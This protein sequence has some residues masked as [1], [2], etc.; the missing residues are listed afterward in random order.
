M[1]ID[2]NEE[3]VL[4]SLVGD[5]FGGTPVFVHVKDNRII[6]VRAMIF[7]ED[8]AKPWSI[9]VGNRVFSPPKRSF[10]APYDLTVR[11]RTYNPQRA[12]YPLKRADFKPG[13]KS[14]TAN[15]GKSEYVRISWDEAL[16][17]IASEL[18]RIKATYGNSAIL[19]H[20]MGHRSSGL[21]NASSLMRRVLNFWGG[22]TPMVRNPDSWEGWYW[23]AKHV[24]GFD[25]SNGNAEALDLLEDTMQHSDLSIFW[26][27][28]IEQSGC[29]IGQDWALWLLWM[30]ELGK[31]MI[32][33]SPD[34]NYTAG[35]KADKQIFI[36]PGTDAALA[37][38]IAYVWISEG[39]YDKDYVHTHT[40][41]FEKWKD[42]VM[43]QEDGIPKTPAWAESIT[44][45][46]AR[47]TRALA[48]EWASKKTH[49]CIRH[50][51]ACR[52]PYSTEWAR[53]MVFLQTMQGLGKPGISIH[54][55]SQA[56]PVDPRIKLPVKMFL[57]AIDS[58]ASTIPEN[59]VKQCLFQTMTPEA[60]LNPPVSWH[61]GAIGAPVEE[62][63][64]KFSYPMSSCS[65]I[66]MI[67]WDTLS[68]ITNWN[69]TNKWAEAYRHP[70]IEFTVAQTPFMENDALF[71]D[72]VLPACT[73]LEREDFSYQGHPL[74]IGQASDWNNFTVVYMK[75]CIK[76]LYES[77]S[78]YEI[79]RL[80]AERL[81]VEK[82]FTEG[83]TPEDWIRK[84][85]EASSLPEHITFEEFK[86]KGY[87][88]FKFP[89]DKDYKRNYGMREFAETATGL[90]TPSGKIE[91]FSQRLF[92]NFP[93]DN[94]RPPI[95]R[96][97]AEGETHQE[98]LSSDK[99]KKYPL[100]MESPH[101]RFRFHSQHETVSWLWEIPTHK[102]IKDGQPVDALWINPIDAEA[103][104]IKHGDL[105]RIFNE[106]GSVLRAAH[107]TG[108]MMP[109]VVRTP[110]GAGY[111]TKLGAINA[112]CPLRT[113]S[114]NAFGMVTTAYLVEVEKWEGK[115]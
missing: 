12:K 97:I 82:E 91:F 108:R 21:V 5:Y 80:V 3:K 83:N 92:D 47:L 29:I 109:S 88:V 87:Y 11:R 96:Y 94:E 40:V 100:L 36:R 57:P 9:K 20:T 39:T 33:I 7:G 2:T 4:T 8:E 41:G 50:G 1:T 67:W 70:K 24:W 90:K 74:M 58:V 84:L 37:A 34:L 78:D 103:R 75:E 51:A 49:L 55:M 85:F 38:A 86:E 16:D 104:G 48:R 113:T 112:I 77:K 89:D 114:K 6:R 61:G 65:E 106:R 93:G 42:Y 44:G 105:A 53:M 13:G 76:P 54:S 27:Y 28:D 111:H 30:K 22:H 115:L 99:A 32:F 14:N 62:Q 68:T 46:P 45:V 73:Q 64:I 25:P 72:I 52:T 95:A 31:K 10:A 81:G 18:T 35:T 23:G 107:V 66:H 110:N 98:S 60:I 101:P 43:G 15:R 19:T 69:N 79:C 102:F 17:I 56:A 26:S 59:P 63:F 71:A